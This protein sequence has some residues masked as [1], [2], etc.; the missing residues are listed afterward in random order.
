MNLKI[1]TLL[2]VILLAGCAAKTE[3]DSGEIA[4]YLPAKQMSGSEILAADLSQLTLEETPLIAPDEIVMYTPA[5]HTLDLKPEAVERLTQMHVPMNGIGFVVCQGKRPL[6]AGAI[7]T[8]L[9][10]QSFDGVTIQVPVFMS[11]TQVQLYSGYPSQDKL[12]PD[13][14]RNDK[15]LLQTLKR[16]GKLK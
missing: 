15:R 12:R 9:S 16:A 10:S 7:W 13:D 6:F 4:I 5:S 8:M 2:L 11:K 14:P 1:A 3:R